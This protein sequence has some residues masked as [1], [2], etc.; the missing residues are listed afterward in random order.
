[1]KNKIGKLII[2][3]L[4][5]IVVYAVLVV[6]SNNTPS[7]RRVRRISRQT[8]CIVNLRWIEEAKEKYAKMYNLTNGAVVRMDALVNSKLLGKYYTCPLANENRNTL[9]DSEESYQANEIGVFPSCKI[10]PAT[11]S[12]SISVATNEILWIV[13][14]SCDARGSATNELL[15]RIHANARAE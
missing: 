4:Y 10:E 8:E 13:R 1:M 11:H 2:V 6:V 12:L 14:E 9:T 3:L 5:T 7:R 15:K